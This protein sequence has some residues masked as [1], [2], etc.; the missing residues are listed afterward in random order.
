MCNCAVGCRSKGERRA[1]R[2][3]G[4]SARFLKAEGAQSQL[5]GAFSASS[6]P[7]PCLFRAH[8]RRWRATVTLNPWSLSLH[9]AQPLSLHPAQ[10]PLRS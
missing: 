1:K 6:W 4:R 7:R 5:E 2:V 8:R 10:P 3:M 9:P